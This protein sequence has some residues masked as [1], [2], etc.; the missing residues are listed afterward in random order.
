MARE[1]T[2]GDDLTA[3]PVRNFHFSL[4]LGSIA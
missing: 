1:L 3:P 2:A 4:P